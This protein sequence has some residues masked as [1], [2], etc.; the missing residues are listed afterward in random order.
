MLNT[1]KNALLTIQALV[2]L[3]VTAI[4]L[5]QSAPSKPLSDDDFTKL[6]QSRLAQVDT[7]AELDDAAKAKVKELY[8]QALAEMAG[9][10]VG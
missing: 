10:E 1:K 7:L 4:T 5:G 8:Q 6:L 9:A 3:S 2:W